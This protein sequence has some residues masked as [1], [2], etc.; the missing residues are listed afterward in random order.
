M[1]VSVQKTVAGAKSVSVARPANF[2]ERDERWFPHW[3]EYRTNDLD[4]FLIGGANVTARGIV[5][6]GLRLFEPALVYPNFKS[7]FGTRYLLQCN[8]FYKELR[9]DDAQSYVL[10]FDHWAIRNYYHWV[11]DTLPRLFAVKDDNSPGRF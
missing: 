8:L 1:R 4:V 6:D 2:V 9:T 5:F 11:V 7:K 3:G 10:A